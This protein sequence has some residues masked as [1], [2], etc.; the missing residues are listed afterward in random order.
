VIIVDKNYTITIDTREEHTNST[1]KNGL[2]VFD[3]NNIPYIRK[4]LA[5]GDYL[6]EDKKDPTNCFVVEKKIISDFVGSVMD[7]RLKQEIEKMNEC[8]SKNYLIIVGQWK[9]YYKDRSVKKARGFVKKVRHF[10]VEQRLGMIASISA[11]TNTKVLQVDNDEQFIELIQKLAEKSTDGQIFT[12]PVFKR[13][14][15]E[16][17]IYVN[18][19]CSFPNISPTKAE[20]IMAVYPTWGSFVEAVLGQIFEL[21]GFGTKSV[22]MFFNFLNE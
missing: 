1:D 9:D 13:A 2:K 22:D 11:R 19:L 5:C 14:K 3:D 17:K 7:G 4:M 21:P 10:A 12:A 15:T 8:Y 18:V 16:D 20:K 6:I